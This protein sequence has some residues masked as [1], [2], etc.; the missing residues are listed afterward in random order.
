[1]SNGNFRGYTITSNYGNRVHPVTKKP[2]SFHRGIDLAKA[3]LSPIKPFIPGEVTV[4][5]DASNIRGFGASYGLIVAIRDKN[6]VTHLYAHLDK[7]LTHVGKKVTTED[8]I[9]L[10]GKTGR[11]TGSHL[12]YEVRSSGVNDTVDPLLYIE[13]YEKK[14]LVSL[15]N[16]TG[17]EC[18]V[19]LDGKLIGK[20]ILVDGKSYFPL[21]E[22]EG[23]RYKIEKWDGATSTVSLKKLD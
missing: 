3:H 8:V 12:H 17:R 14:E 13:E 1:M 20:G 16:I 7:V 5:G 23:I 18:N 21:R 9:G 22:L 4:A 2:D 19:L 11:V 10:Q 6:N 15:K